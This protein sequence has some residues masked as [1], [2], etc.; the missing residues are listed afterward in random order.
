M[1]LAIGYAILV[2]ILSIGGLFLN[3]GLIFTIL[4]KVQ[5]R[6]SFHLTLISLS[7]ADIFACIGSTSFGLL[8]LLRRHISNYQIIS[9][10]SLFFVYFSNMASF[11]HVIFI[12][13]LRAFATMYPMKFK[14]S[15]GGC[16]FF[17]VIASVWLLS[18]V[19]LLLVTFQVVHFLVI[20]YVATVTCVALI[21]LYLLICLYLRRQQRSIAAASTQRKSQKANI[22]VLLHSIAVT[23][24]FIACVIPSAVFAILR[25]PGGFIAFV[26]VT[27]LLVLN[28]LIDPL[29]YFFISHFRMHRQGS[30]QNVTPN[31]RLT[32]QNITTQL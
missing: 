18:L 24:A 6:S 3:L 21:F 32:R 9:T 13:F 28:P 2:V 10:A 17:L 16:H 12:A 4:R 8:F 26:S 15:C 29:L 23:V 5:R 7:C 20:G 25:F 27:S 19:F 22:V 31:E 1:D 11:M 30:S 14:T